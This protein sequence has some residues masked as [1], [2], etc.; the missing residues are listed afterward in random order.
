M[1]VFHMKSKIFGIIGF[2]IGAVVG[3]IFAIG[4]VEGMMLGGAA[5][6][7]GG[8]GI[9]A[10]VCLIIGGLILGGIGFSVGKKLDNKQ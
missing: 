1:E 5:P 7:E 6:G 4:V 8:A 3:W 2:P 9:I 10:V